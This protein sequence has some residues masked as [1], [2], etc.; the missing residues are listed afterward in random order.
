MSRPSLPIESKCYGCGACR[1]SCPTGALSMRYSENDFLFYEVDEDLCVSCGK[2]ERVCPSLN[3]SFGN[4]NL[5]AFYAF[6]ASD[7]IR[8]ESSSGGMFTVLA[9]YI[10][11]K[12]GVVCAAAFDDN[13]V[14]RHQFA[15]SPED[16]PKF[17][18]SKYLQ[19]EM[20]D[21]YP[22]IKEY[23]VDGTPL[24]FVGT[25]C[26]VAALKNYLGK[27]YDELVLIDLLCHGTPSQLLFNRYLDEV[28]QGKQVES[29]SFRSKRFG[30]SWS[31]ILTTFADGTEHIGTTRSKNKDPYMVA[32]NKNLMMR[33]TCYDCQYCDYP[34]QGDITIGDLWEYQKF[35]KNCND[36]KGTSFVFLN[37]AR[38][39]AIY[40]DIE[41]QA[42]Y[43][44]QI[45]LKP[46]QYK[47]IPNRVRPQTKP[48][49]HRARFI[50]LSRTMPF[51][52]A[53]RQ[54]MRHHF[55]IGLPTVLYGA[56][57][58]N[59]LTYWALYQVLTDMG[60]TVRLFEKP[61]DSS[62]GD[63]P[64]AMQFCRQWLPEW[65]LPRRFP[66]M[67]DMRILND[68]CD[69]FLVGSDQVYLEDMSHKRNDI[70]FLQYVT[71]TKKKSA[72]ASSFGGPG[73]RGSAKY[74]DYVKYYLNKFDVVTCRE[75][76]GVDFANN[77]L[78]LDT[79]VKYVLDPV[80]LCSKEHYQKLID[81]TPSL[82]DTQFIGAYVVKPR[83][84]MTKLISNAQ[85][86]LG[87]RTVKCAV[88]LY[89]TNKNKDLS[90]FDCFDSFPVERVLRTIH[91]SALFVTDSYHGVCFSI[92]FRK[93]FI[94]IPRDFEDRFVSLLSR[95]GLEGRIIEGDLSNYSDDLLIN[96]IDYDAVY[97]KLGELIESS[98]E[99]LRDALTAE[100]KESR[101]SDLDVAMDYI[102]NQQKTIK[103]M[104][105]AL[106]TTNETIA[107]LTEKIERLE[108]SQE[109]VQEQEKGKT[110]EPEQKQEQKKASKLSFF[111][112]RKRN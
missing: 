96:H 68:H 33:Q 11:N 83:E 66:S 53:A 103:K 46:E 6:C 54:A 56:N 35:D 99:L 36:G 112:R 94:V 31:T 111:D 92:I 41:T 108:S 4:D 85:E 88:H 45:T 58:G 26:Q 9:E 40:Q 63:S 70:F 93:D 90:Q 3:P 105:A 44:N 24:L 86:A 2:C 55:D 48:H 69:Q 97:E 38:G 25:P 77:T 22:R 39:K 21:T 65:A 14:L 7:D 62:L 13:F 16:L 107:R 1:C 47:T 87:I 20:G 64:E 18:G 75:D 17:R 12:G 37:N 34:R 110:A 80:F 49:P 15:Y 100:K 81:S 84:R 60:Y 52:S 43:S 67:L 19:S 91:D 32:F 30:W 106:K 95:I 79:E 5:P 61:L 29:V 72:Y 27:D 73:A 101:L 28:A 71:G 104:N 23:L 109:Q 59:V 10:F 98:S 78:S 8:T 50:D 82:C 76:D 57:I 89:E 74:Y 42:S 51:S 102:S